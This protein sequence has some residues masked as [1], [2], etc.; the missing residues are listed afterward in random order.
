MPVT[1]RPAKHNGPSG[2][3]SRR[4][5]AEVLARGGGAYFGGGATSAG[6][7]TAASVSRVTS[8]R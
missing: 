5:P 3:L 4:A 7:G 6:V 1:E 2:P 8:S